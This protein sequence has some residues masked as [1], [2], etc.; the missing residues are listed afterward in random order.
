MGSVNFTKNDEVTPYVEN[1]IGNLTGHTSRALD[2]ISDIEV[3]YMQSENPIGETHELNDMAMWEATGDLKRYIFSGSGHFD[4][5][6]D[7]HVILGPLLTERQRKWWFWYLNAVLGGSYDVKYGTGSSTPPN[8]YP[9][10]ALDASDADVDIRLD[11][12]LNDL[13]GG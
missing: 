3:E 1:V 11:Q 2:D 6:V 7:G 10:R 13:L 4:P 8:D 5:I 12:Y 9:A